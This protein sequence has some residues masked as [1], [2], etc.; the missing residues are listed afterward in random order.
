[1]NVFN[2]NINLKK[3][4][5]S[6]FVWMCLS[7]VVAGAM[8]CTQVQAAGAQWIWK[9][10]KGSKVYSDTPPPAS[11]P[12]SRIIKSPR[13]AAAASQKRRRTLA[14]KPVGLVD[15]KVARGEMDDASVEAKGDG[16]DSK[17]EGKDS[18]SELDKKVE[19][20]RKK[21]EAAQKEKE[22][23]EEEKLAQE[24]RAQQEKN[25]KRIAQAKRNLTSGSRIS[26][27]GEDGQKRF[28]SEDE[29][30]SRMEQLAEAEESNE[31]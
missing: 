11:V 2:N 23:A 20:K 26:A 3:S 28:L 22:Q 25:C 5:G 8:L 27:V 13:Q 9:N 21:K 18:M 16:A 6:G 4:N 7:V 30:Q 17:K 10:A 1:M 12:K 15:A 14:N 24:R 29:V 19:A 31:C